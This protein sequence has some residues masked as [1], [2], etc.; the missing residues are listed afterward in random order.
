MGDCS[1]DLWTWLSREHLI[2]RGHTILLWDYVAE[3]ISFVIAAHWQIIHQN[4]K[5][6]PPNE[7]IRKYMDPKQDNKKRKRGRGGLRCCSIVSCLCLNRFL[8]RMFGL[9]WHTRCTY[10]QWRLHTSSAVRRILK[11]N[12]TNPHVCKLICTTYTNCHG[13]L[14]SLIMFLNPKITGS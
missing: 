2:T 1:L 7:Q 3:H 12:K 6:N 11:P 4:A 8:L 5:A 9:S 10:T 14:G 13:F